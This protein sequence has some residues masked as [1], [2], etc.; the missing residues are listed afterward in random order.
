MNPLLHRAAALIVLTMSLQAA[1]LPAGTAPLVSVPRFANPGAGQVFYF[2]LTDRFANGSTANDTGGLGGDRNLN[3]FD[4]TAISHYHGGDFLGLT[5]RLDYIKGLGATA[6]WITPP[7]ANKAVQDGTAGYHGYWILDFLHID[8]HLGTDAEF[9]EFVAQAHARGL[10][11]YLD[12]VTNHTADVI[13]YRDGGTA[14]IDIAHAPYRDAF[15]RPFDEHAAAYNG[16]NSP[17]LFPRLSA[18]RSFAHV[19][20]LAPADAHAK[21]PDWLNDVTLY[22]NRGNSSFQGES[23]LHGDFGGLDDLFTENPAVVRGF[24]GI[25]GHWMESYGIDGFR[26]DTVKHVNREFWQ[27]FAP[28]LHARARGLGRPDF[29]MFGEVAMGRL[30]AAFASEFSNTG[31]LDATLD[32]GFFHAARDFVSRGAGAGVLN[33]LFEADSYFTGPDRNA[34][35]MPTFISN[36]DDGRFG[37]F[38]KQDNPGADARRLLRMEELGYGLLFLV[39]GQPVVYYG[40]EQGMTGFGGDMAAREDMFASRAPAYRALRLLGTSRTGA[41]DKFDEAHPL[42]RLVRSLALLRA[43]HPALSRGSMI[44]RESDR[45]QVF[46]FSR[47]ERAEQVE[48]LAA[49]NSSQDGA[50]SVSLPTSQP[51]GSTFRRIFD[52][53]SPDDPGSQTLTAGADGHVRVALA[54]LQFS[55]WRAAR[56]LPI[57]ASPPRIALTSPSEGAT[58]AFSAREVDGHTIV[59]RREVRAEVAGG[60]GLAEVTFVLT[61]ASRPGQYELLGTEDSPPYRVFWRPPADLARGELLTFIATLDDLRGHR[62]SASVGNVAV[63][64]GR[65]EF[66][67]QGAMVPRLEREPP[68]RV[69]LAAG[70][71]LHLAAEATG[72]PPL[73][74]QWFHNGAAIPGATGT[75][76]DLPSASPEAAGRYFLLVRDREGTTVSAESAVVVTTSR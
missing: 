66:G 2:V 6:I 68:G 25:Y 60:D 7:F 40:D 52:S 45:P 12:I 16:L 32:F 54:P 15:G 61:R 33:S 24:I 10:R 62:A 63:E 9:R 19:P 35:E 14:Y 56:R 71:P 8:P 42:Y 36:H 65:L 20:F 48:C 67:I 46:A 55:V 43:T 13:A 76:Y 37:Y 41:D 34:G 4:P 28:A 49:L 11:V 59:N 27:A 38:L 3:G 1:R 31:M 51:A 39:R 64:P 17:D 53:D 50:A 30:D 26:I 5:A 47:F 70:D 74:Y 29:F 69:L 44:E 23:S 58:L 18:E 57:P 73:D 72:T 75:A 21:F 22:H